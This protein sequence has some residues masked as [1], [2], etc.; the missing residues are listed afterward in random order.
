MSVHYQNL[1]KMLT[2]ADDGPVVLSPS[3]KRA[4]RWAVSMINTL[5]DA[6]A[7]QSGLPIP[8]VL[9]R[10]S[11]IVEQSEGFNWPA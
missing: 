3:G 10:V 2:I 5:G 9:D 7:D 4:I 11:K 1:L 6:V 8:V